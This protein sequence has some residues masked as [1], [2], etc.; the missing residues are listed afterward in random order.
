MQ[1]RLANWC[2]DKRK[3]EEKC[4]KYFKKLFVTLKDNKKTPHLWNIEITGS[5]SVI[6]LICPLT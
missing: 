4:S 5:I 6:V 1:I 2:E 3:R